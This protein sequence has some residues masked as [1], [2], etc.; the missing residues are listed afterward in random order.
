MAEPAAP[1]VT[2]KERRIQRFASLAVRGLYRSVEVYAAAETPGNGPVLAVS[3]HFGGFADPLLLVSVAPRTPRIV[4][5][6]K[7]WQ[8]PIAGGVMRWLRAIPV[9]KPEEH[10]GLT[11]NDQMFASCY[12]ALEEDSLLLIFPEGITVDD[13]SIASIKTGAARIAL[14]ARANGVEGI[15]I[16]PAGIHY[17][18]KAA[19]RSRVFINIGAPLS[20]DGGLGRYDGGGDDETPENRELVLA[21]TNEIEDRLRRVAPDFADWDEAKSLTS[22]AEVTLRARQENPGDEVPASI[23]DRLAGKLGRSPADKK[24]AVTEAITTYDQDLDAVGLT[25]AQSY[26]HTTFFG[27]LWYAVWNIALGFVLLPFAVV[28]IVI[29]FIPLLIVWAI[30]LLR[31]SP[32]VKA[33]LKPMAALVL[34]PLAWGIGA[35][36]LASR[37]ASAFW[38]IVAIVLIPLYLA[39]AILLSERLVLLWRAWQSWRGNRNLARVGNKIAAERQAVISAVNAAVDDGAESSRA[40]PAG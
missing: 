32:A 15:Q 31:V 22:A 19:L 25:D 39:A 30:G 29:N 8:I 18:N 11:S 17:E 2:R 6:D 16:I 20:L 14:G 34:F 24:Q 1:Q 12:T 10:K 40:N 3:N 38:T 21:L 33:T 7:I 37:G 36:Q 27:F 4:A 5:R 26:D 35:W 9:H 23:R 28:G 13:P